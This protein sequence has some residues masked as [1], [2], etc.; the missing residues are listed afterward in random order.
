LICIFRCKQKCFQILPLVILQLFNSSGLIRMICNTR[1]GDKSSASASSEDVINVSTSHLLDKVL[2]LFRLPEG[3]VP[4]DI[5]LVDVVVIVELV[6]S[7]DLK[8]VVIVKAL[9]FS[10][11]LAQNV[12]LAAVVVD[13]LLTGWCS[14]QKSD[15]VV[16]GGNIL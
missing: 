15:G 2:D 10:P 8:E 14:F 13:A 5:W 7:L 4:V 9:L 12:Q 1:L 6:V 16:G 3:L 11:V